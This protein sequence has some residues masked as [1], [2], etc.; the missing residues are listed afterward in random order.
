MGFAMPSPATKTCSADV[1]TRKNKA[2]NI[3]NLE[4]NFIDGEGIK[5]IARALQETP[6]AA[7]E[8]LRLSNQAG[9]DVMGRTVE[10]A[11]SQMM[12]ANLGPVGFHMMSIGG[13]C[14]W[15]ARVFDSRN[16]GR[17]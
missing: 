8:T 17:E 5:A 10:Q 16:L 12:Q 9:T 15:P 7:V 6:D 1:G 13:A 2:L 11:V 14:S 3:V 4:S